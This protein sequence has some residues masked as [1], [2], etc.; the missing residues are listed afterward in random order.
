MSFEGMLVLVLGV[1]GGVGG[2][3]LFG[4]LRGSKGGGRVSAGA[5]ERAEQAHEQVD[6][7]LAA[8]GDREQDHAA[9]EER[10]KS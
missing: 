7:D 1:L 5:A 3:I 9:V 6:R 10:W 8:K 2:V 4:W